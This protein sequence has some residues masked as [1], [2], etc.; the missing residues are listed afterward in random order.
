MNQLLNETRELKLNGDQ[1][2]SSALDT[3]DTENQTLAFQ[4]ALGCYNQAYLNLRSLD[5][6]EEGNQGD[7]VNSLIKSRGPKEEDK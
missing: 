5:V 7:F 3:P 2:L 4:K 1:F 6:S